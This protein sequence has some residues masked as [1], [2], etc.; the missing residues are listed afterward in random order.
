M[1]K[2]LIK[3]PLENDLRHD[4]MTLKNI[5]SAIEIIEPIE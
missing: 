2:D 5:G 4:V 3:C 1:L